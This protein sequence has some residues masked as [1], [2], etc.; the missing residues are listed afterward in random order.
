M[1]I[2]YVLDENFVKNMYINYELLYVKNEGKL[3]F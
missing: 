2:Y 3:S 1:F